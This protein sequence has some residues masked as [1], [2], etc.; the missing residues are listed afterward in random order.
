[1]ERIID[2]HTVEEHLVLDRRAAS[3]IQLSALV[4][5]KHHSGDDLK[6]LRQ[7]RLAA[8]RRELTDSLRCDIDDRRL[9]LCASLHLFGSD[10]DSLKLY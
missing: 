4:T 6:I 8:N 10:I 9:R 3:Y 2:N 7:V 5:R 1:M